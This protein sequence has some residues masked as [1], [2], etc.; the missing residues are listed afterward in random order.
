MCFP[1]NSVLR[2][3]TK[4]QNLILKDNIFNSTLPYIILILV[5]CRVQLYINLYHRC[6]GV[7]ND[8]LSS[9]IICSKITHFFHLMIINL[10]KIFFSYFC[11]QLHSTRSRELE[12]VYLSCIHTTLT[13][14]KALQPW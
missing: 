2:R 8:N 12:N 3:S 1:A 10:K 5:L 4:L 13:E 14:N 6:K 11:K 9:L 7:S